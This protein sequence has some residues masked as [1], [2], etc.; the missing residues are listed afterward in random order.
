MTEMEDDTNKRKDFPC[1][2]IERK[3]IVKISMLPKAIYTFNSIP[4]KKP[5]VFFTVLEQTIL[6]FVWNL[7]RP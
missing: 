1:S 7:K 5:E 4:I 3:N 6:K 2:W